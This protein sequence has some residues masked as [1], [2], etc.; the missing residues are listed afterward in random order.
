MISETT[1]IP[2]AGSAPGRI[3]SR[4]VLTTIAS[5]G[6]A[7][8]TTNVFAAGTFHVSGGNPAC[9]ELGPGTPANPYCTIDAAVEAQG[10]P[11]TTILVEPGIYREEV[12]IPTSMSGN[13]SDR[14]IIKA[15]APGVV[16]DGADDFSD[17]G[18]WTQIDGPVW[19]AA[20]VTWDANQVLVDGSRLIDSTEDPNALSS[21][22]FRYVPGTGLYANVGGGNPGGQEIMVGRRPDGIRLDG[23]SW[24]TIDGFTVTRIDDIGIYLAEGCIDVVIVRNTVTHSFSDGIG[25]N[26]CTGALIEDNHVTR[27]AD[28]GIYLWN[29]TTNTTLR[30]NESSWSRRIVG[31][32]AKGIKV[33]SCDNIVV[34]SSRLHHNEDSGLRVDLSTDTLS[35]QNLAWANDGQGFSDRAS[36][37]SRYIG[38][39]AHGNVLAGFAVV[40]GSQQASLLNT[41]SV[42]NG[43]TVLGH[44]LQVDSS[45]TTGFQSDFNVLFGAPGSPGLISYAGTDYASVAAY[46]TA[47]GHDASTLQQDPLFVD[48]ASANFHLQP[49]SPAIDS[50]DSSAVDFPAFD[51]EGNPRVDDPVAAN[52][53]AGPVPYAERGAFEFDALCFGAGG[54]SCGDTDAGECV[55]GTMQC[56][57]GSLICTGAVGPEAESC[58]GLDD[59]CDGVDDNGFDLGAFCDGA[60]ECGAGITECNGVGGTRC[61]T[62]VGGSGDQSLPET[63]D[64]LDND[65]DGTAD[66]GFGVGS[67]CD[68]DGECGIGVIEC[69]GTSAVRCSTAPG[70]SA[71]QSVPETC[72]SL[73]NDCDGAADDNLG[74]TTCGVG[75]CEVTVTSCVDGVPQSCEPLSPTTETCDSLD[76][77]C[78]GVADDGFDVGAACDGAGECGAGVTECDGVGGA[79]CSTDV[80]GSADQSVAETCDSLDND[81]DGSADEEI[82]PL[83]CGVGQCEVTVASCVDGVPQSCTPG[84]PSDE[85][86]DSLDNDCD[87][88]ADEGLAPLTCGVGQCEVTVAS[89]VDGVPQ[90]CTPGAPSD[91]TC[92]SLD[93]DCDGVADDGFDLGV[94]CDG[95]GECGAGVREC[96]G[97]GG[98]R[99]STDVGGSGDQSVPE[100]CDTLDND[101]DGL[102]DDGFD[103]GA[104]CDGAGECGAGV[105]E[106][107]GSGGARCSTDIG[108]SADQSVPETCDTLDNDC[109]GSADEDIAPLTCGVGQCEVTVASCVDGVPQSCTPGAP[110]DETCDSLDNDCDGT[111]DDGF[112]LGAACD[113]AGECGAGAR[114]CDGVGGARCSTDVGGSADQSVPETCDSLDNDCDGLAD[115][116][117]DIGAACDGAGECGAGVRECDGTAAVRC[118]TD[119]GGSADQS[120]AE[121]CDSLDNDCDGTADEDIAPL[122]CGVG[123]C[124]VTVA[125]CVDGVPQSC[126][127]LSPTTETCDS[128]DNDCDGTADDGFDIGAACDGAG[129]CGAGVRECDGSG[130]AHCSTD[131]GG[132]GDQSVPETCDTLDN[133]CDGLADDGFDIGAA[134]DGACGAGVRECDGSGGARC[135]TDIGGSGDQC[136]VPAG[137][138]CNHRHRRLGFDQSVPETCDGLDNDCNGAPSMTATPTRIST[139]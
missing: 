42:N 80:G 113:G 21:G 16:V 78:D 65:C 104:A 100:T 111:A 116:G 131:I 34:A 99:C 88:T 72:D 81:C 136:D 1:V 71:D 70:G 98:A 32:G 130:G 41:I 18:L 117:F 102:A 27:S 109:D 47:T 40:E 28:H 74:E 121:T 9:S 127:P 8:L 43:A 36:I 11:G 35:L 46:T 48:A 93:N 30:G 45:S 64:S 138:R 20:G 76:N 128:L 135:S 91:E 96:D 14:F 120:V 82:A 124:E 75:Q 123:Q 26:G 129:E 85:T 39:V 110:S 119:I 69:A 77:D 114:E 118:S 3:A 125:S 57:T 94:A 31:T 73:D 37:G 22:T 29:G 67:Q 139:R 115:D 112:D 108:G 17:T 58:N 13:A 90:S 122:T 4:R 95:A 101:C 86:C 126:E 6:A 25:V 61:S 106:C 12:V 10:G 44:N 89:C 56:V 15:S 133:D 60:G 51:A 38:D 66:D 7:L 105:R 87:G 132:S 68:G 92:D 134:C 84:A 137:A 23:G 19:L 97:V 55:L 52:N 54:A 62:D 83:T 59:D 107:D 2:R 63:C 50:A 33:E 49:G 79:R 53:G 24:I 103:L 5:L